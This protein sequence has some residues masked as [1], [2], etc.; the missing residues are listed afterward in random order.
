MMRLSEYFSAGEMSFS[1]VCS[2]RNRERMPTGL[3]A[4]SHLTCSPQHQQISYVEYHLIPRLLPRP[5]RFAPARFSAAVQSTADGTAADC[6]F[7]HPCVVLC[8]S[9]ASF[10]CTFFKCNTTPSPGG[11]SAGGG[12]SI[13]ATSRAR[14]AIRVVLPNSLLLHVMPVHL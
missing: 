12:W 1:V 11:C 3:P 6:S 2:A 14:A 8:L 9:S 7:T 5:H 4:F 13:P 10:T